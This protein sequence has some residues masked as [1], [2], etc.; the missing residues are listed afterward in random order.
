[1][2]K[3][4]FLLFPEIC[5]CYCVRQKNDPQRCPCLNPRTCDYITSY[6]K[7]DIIDVIKDLDMGKL[8]CVS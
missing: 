1:M 7:D 5:L 6:G 3:T 8:S 4:I 2:L